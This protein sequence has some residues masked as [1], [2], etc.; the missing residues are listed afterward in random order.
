MKESSQPERPPP[1]PP[2]AQYLA[3]K[4]TCLS[5]LIEDLRTGD[6]DFAAEAQDAIGGTSSK[7]VE[8]AGYVSLLLVS[9]EI[10]DISIDGQT[11]KRV[12][13]HTTESE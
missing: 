12:H 6:V 8:A 2:H 11:I 10:G 13:I 5:E 3:S 9:A 4:S 7:I 1:G